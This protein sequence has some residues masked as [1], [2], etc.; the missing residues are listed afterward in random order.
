[1][2]K[3]SGFQKS[4]F[5]QF[6]IGDIKAVVLT[7]GYIP[8][9]PI[10]PFM[11]PI[12]ETEQLKE[13]LQK[14]YQREDTVDLSINIPLLRINDR[15]IMIDTGS[16]KYMGE[17]SGW[18][19]DNLKLAGI[20]PNEITDILLTHALLDHVGGLVSDGKS[21]FPNAVIYLS[22]A[23]HEFW[24][25]GKPD[26]NENK[27][28]SKA[29]DWLHIMR[30]QINEILEVVKPQLQLLEDGETILDCITVEIALGHTDGHLVTTISSKGESMV[31]IADIIHT[32]PLLFA[33][34]EWGTGFD[35]HFDQAV[36]T[37]INILNRLNSNNDWIIGIHLPYPGIGHIREIKS[38]S[39]EWIPTTF[40]S[41]AI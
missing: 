17:N 9:S 37:R 33:H 30:G 35:T 5:Q 18:L 2:N 22:R 27:G 29:K 38:N 23:E 10:Q 21:V 24:K 32:G 28:G 12:A 26:L 4:G 39:Y 25:D 13:Q 36:E 3:E 6:Q 19:L 34:P 20:N 14:T 8:I 41:L 1:M 11:A 15:L 7:D 16:G 31:H 40:A